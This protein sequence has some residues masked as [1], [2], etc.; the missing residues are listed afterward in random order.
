[1]LRCDS[2]APLGWPCGAHGQET[3]RA[4]RAGGATRNCGA[5]GELDVARV[6][7]IDARRHQCMAASD[8]R[9][10]RD[11]ARRHGRAHLDDKLQ[12]RNVAG[13]L[14]DRVVVGRLQHGLQHESADAHQLGGVV[15]LGRAIRR[16]HV[17]EHQARQCGRHLRHDPLPAVARPDADA[18][19]VA[20]PQAL[21]A[22]GQGTRAP[23]S[24]GKGQPHAL[25]VV[26]DEHAFRCIRNDSLEFLTAD[27]SRR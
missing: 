9:V 7:W 14:E 26:D 8:E 17:D 6:V 22:R 13:L 10:E 23:C 25:W 1:M 4:I 12:R 27:V 21:Q 24:F 3:W 18:V 11:A 20:Q 2:V 16:V 15:Q 5:A 19:A